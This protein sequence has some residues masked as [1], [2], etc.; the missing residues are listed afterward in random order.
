MLKNILNKKGISMAAPMSMFG[1]WIVFYMIATVIV[2]KMGSNP[3]YAGFGLILWMIIWGYIGIKVEN[4]KNDV[5]FKKLDAT[6]VNEKARKL[7]KL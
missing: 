7:K 3:D 2:S 4:Q 6:M 1:M 5:F